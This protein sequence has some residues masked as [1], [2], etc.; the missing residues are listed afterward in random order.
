MAEKAPALK[1]SGSLVPLLEDTPAANLKL[2]AAWDGLSVESQI[3]IL[4]TFRERE[5][6]IS[7]D[8]ALQALASPNAYVRYLAAVTVEDAAVEPPDEQV[9]EDADAS[10]ADPDGSQDMLRLAERI[11]RDDNPLVRYALLER[12]SPLSWKPNEEEID[13]YLHQPLHARL[14]VLRGLFSGEECACIIRRA[15]T[16]GLVPKGEIV[17]MAKEYVGQPG[18]LEFAEIDPGRDGAAAWAIGREFE[19]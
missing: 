12:H 13:A 5:R 1:V 16:S 11:Q 8:V 9:D 15:V 18:H 17:T 10:L 4:T 3:A 19:A 2:L 14:A 7:K 6:S